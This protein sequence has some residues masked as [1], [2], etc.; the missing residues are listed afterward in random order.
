MKKLRSAWG[1]PGRLWL[2]EEVEGAV[3]GAGVA[4]V[5]VAQRRDQ[6]PRSVGARMQADRSTGSR[7]FEEDD[8]DRWREDERRS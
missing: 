7:E 8:D 6:A 1:S 3:V 5:W 2:R 4:E